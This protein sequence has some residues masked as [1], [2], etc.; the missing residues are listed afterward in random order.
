MI[1]LEGYLM[2]LVSTYLQ[3]DTT[4]TFAELEKEEASATFITIMI[5][6][7][8]VITPIAFIYLVT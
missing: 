7:S 4:Y 3:F 6:F 2:V 5:I 8:L 1:I